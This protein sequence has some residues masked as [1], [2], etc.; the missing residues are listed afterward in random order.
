MWNMVIELLQGASNAKKKEKE[1]KRKEKE[2]KREFLFSR[3]ERSG[4]YIDKVTSC[5]GPPP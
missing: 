5:K 4:T 2:K 1:K 3:A